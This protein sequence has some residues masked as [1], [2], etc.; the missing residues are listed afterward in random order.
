M[1]GI[2]EVNGCYQGAGVTD[3]DQSAFL[4][5]SPRPKSRRPFGQVRSSTTPKARERHH[6]PPVHN[7]QE[8]FARFDCLSHYFRDGLALAM[9]FALELSCEI[10][11]KADGYA[12]HTCIL[13]YTHRPA[14]QKEAG[15]S[16][17]HPASMCAISVATSR[18]RTGSRDRRRCPPGRIREPCCR[19]E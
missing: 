6:T 17:E 18:R 12:L 9:G 1:V 14:T 19:R 4:G 13:A 5:S 8:A 2:C 11:R 15:R 3:C 7:R 10:V 16:S